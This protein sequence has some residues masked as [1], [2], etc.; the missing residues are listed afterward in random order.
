[1]DSLAIGQAAD[2]HLY[3]DEGADTFGNIA[4]N[5]H[6]HIPNLQKLGISNLHPL[7]GVQ[8]LAIL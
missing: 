4:K 5:Y 3:G 6:L 1:M 2:A 7:K 8:K